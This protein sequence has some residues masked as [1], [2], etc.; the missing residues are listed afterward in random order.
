MDFEFS[1]EQQAV[2]D[3]ASQ[4]LEGTISHERLREMKASGEH[5][6]RRAWSELANAGL[7]GIALPEAYGGAGQ[8]F[9]S[10][11]LV[12]EQ[13]GRHVAPVP[14]FASAVLGAMPI[15]QFGTEAQKERLLPAAA[16][17]ELIL[18]GA[19]IELGT[20]AENPYTTAA[21]GA[22]GAWTLTGQKDCVPAGLD[23]GQIVVSART[24]DGVGLFLLDPTAAG[25]E[26]IRQDTTNHIPEARLVLSAAPAELL[27][28][29]AEALEWTRQHAVTALC[30]MGIGVFDKEVRMTAEYTSTRKQFDKPLAHFQA[31][32]QRAAD[33]YIDT[34][35]IRLTTWQAAW[36]LETG[37]PAAMEVAT[38]KYWLSDGGQ[39]VA[40]AAQHLHGGIGVDTDYPLHRYYLWA[41][42]LQLHLGGASEH[43]QTLGRLLVG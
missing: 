28:E 15:A 41:K 23:A 2:R 29:G 24:A 14:Y 40:A 19:Y 34:E 26:V 10:A 32:G 18:T 6:E 8:G 21:P 38:A 30:A 3:L 39:R 7:V 33:A 20:Q 4:I 35:A 1:D 31:V 42:W 16:S 22:D 36:R 9:V 11:V 37:L 43:L 13:I 5:L 27:V 17:G 12:L 25:V